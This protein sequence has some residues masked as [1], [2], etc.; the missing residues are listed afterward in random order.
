[1]TTPLFEFSFMHERDVFSSL[2]T[3]VICFANDSAQAKCGGPSEQNRS[4]ELE[5]AGIKL[6]VCTLLCDQ[7]VV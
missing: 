6:I 1:M 4:L 7:L 3:R 5:C 2:C